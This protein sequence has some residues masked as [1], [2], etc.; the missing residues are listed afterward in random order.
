[1]KLCT[2]CKQEKDE[3]L[4]GRHRASKDGLR[5]VCK[6]CHVKSNMEW[7]KKNKEKV[8]AYRKSY[9]V[10]NKEKIS[11]SRATRKDDKSTYDM[12]RYKRTKQ[13][14][15]ERANK[16]REEN[17]QATRAIVNR[18]KKKAYWAERF[19]RFGITEQ[20]YQDLAQQGCQICGSRKMLRMDHDHKTE[21]FRGILCHSCNTAL[22]LFRDNT[23]TIKAAIG[24]VL[25]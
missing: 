4:F 17:P 21:R 24:Y 5:N 18:Y 1:M 6:D 12:E 25:S 3:I 13:D 8:Q 2:K 20:Q 22:G 23:E 7:G 11:A 19:A 14:V 9:S 10:K 16:W 15:I